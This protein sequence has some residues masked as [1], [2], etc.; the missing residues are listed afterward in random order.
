MSLRINLI[1]DS[2]RRSASPIQ[3]QTLVRMGIVV[4]ALIPVLIGLALFTGHRR[5]RME[6]DRTRT[7]WTQ[8]KPRYEEALR[9][10]QDLARQQSLMKE[11][12]GYRATRIAWSEQLE[13]LRDVVPQVVQL[14]ELH[15]SQQLL[16]SNGVPA[17]AFE[18]RLTGRAAGQQAEVSVRFLRDALAAREPFTPAVDTNSVSVPPGAFRQDPARGASKLDRVFEIVARYQPRRFE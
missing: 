11:I 9:I 16:Q 2:E 14:T 12:S 1:L 8:A 13:G 5:F 18:L 10:K 3:P 4:L 15:V 17:R 6:L 7:E